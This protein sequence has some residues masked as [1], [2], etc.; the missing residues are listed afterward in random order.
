MI[1][2]HIVLCTVDCVLKISHVEPS[3]EEDIVTTWEGS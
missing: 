1:I 2:M 3:M